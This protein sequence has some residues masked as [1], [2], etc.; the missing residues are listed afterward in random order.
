MVV[1]LR[2]VWGAEV[3]HERQ[4]SDRSIRDHL[5]K[6]NPNALKVRGKEEESF[7]VE[8]KISLVS[9]LYLCVFLLL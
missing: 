8:Y 9:K 1:L 2:V 3:W 7:K 6:E 5:M 4:C